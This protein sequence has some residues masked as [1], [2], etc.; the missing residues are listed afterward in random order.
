MIGQCPHCGATLGP[1]ES[2]HGCLLC[3]G[4]ALQ[5]NPDRVIGVLE[6]AGSPIAHW[7]V[8][9]L[10]ERDAGCTHPGSVQVWLSADPRACWGGPGVY[11]LYRHGLLPGPRD[12]GITA[13]VFLSATEYALSQD[14]L[15]F[16]LQ[17]AGYRFQITSL[18]A[19]LSRAEGQGLVD[20]AGGGW[21]A[22]PLPLGDLLGLSDSEDVEVV[23]ERTKSQMTA[24]LLERDRRLS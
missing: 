1:A 19:A 13:A 12:L 15:Y 6:E 2:P 16:A 8:R 3:Q 17:H 24:A 9:R 22:A 14:E 20:W 11:G 23:L 18:Y 7:D 5:T 4:A 10:L 21:Q